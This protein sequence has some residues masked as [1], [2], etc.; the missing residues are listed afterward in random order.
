MNFRPHR[1][2]LI[3]SLIVL[4]AATVIGSHYFSGFC[5]TTEVAYPC[6]DDYCPTYENPCSPW[7]PSI[8]SIVLIFFGIP[9][10]V[11]SY[12]VYSLLEKRK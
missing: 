9:G 6:T 11:I 8:F 1:K 3:I 4:I 5:V 10:F 7:N 2:K 12:V